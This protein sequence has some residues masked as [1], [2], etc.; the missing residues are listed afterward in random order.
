[1]NLDVASATHAGRIRS[2]NEDCIAVDA[3]AGVAVLADGMGGHNAGEVASRMAVE[4]ASA[5][6]KSYRAR[7]RRIDADQWEALVEAQIAAANSAIFE[8]A[9]GHRQYRGM[10]TTL[11]VAVWHERGVSYGH[12]GDS[13][14]YRLRSGALAQLTR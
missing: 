12:I 13:R 9:A 7:G 4:V 1:M 10:G 8:A 3:E 11:V 5:N 2:Q 14:L 6:L